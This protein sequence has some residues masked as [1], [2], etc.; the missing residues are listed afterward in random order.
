MIT[1]E[2]RIEALKG[3]LASLFASQRTLKSLAPQFKWAGLGNLLGDYGEFVAIEVYGLHPAPRGANGYDAMTS[4]GKKVQV[5]ANFAASQIG[6]RGEA[7][8]LLCLKIDLTGD[9]TE[10]YYGDFGLVKNVARYS[11]RDNKHMVPLT[12]L[13][14]IAE[15]GYV[16]TGP[17]P[18]VQE[19]SGLEETI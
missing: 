10:I 2:Q 19:T 8:L 6:F 13:R 16:V 1:K 3:V 4:D 17:L 18:E 12:A 14:K 9:W 11:A 5:K 7:D 15:A